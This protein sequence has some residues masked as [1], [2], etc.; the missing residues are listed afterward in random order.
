MEGEGFATMM[1]VTMDCMFQERENTIGLDKA[2]EMIM[3]KTSH[4]TWRLTNQD[5]YERH[6][7]VEAVKQ[8]HK[9]I[10]P[11]LHIE[12]LELQAENRGWEE[13]ERG[14]LEAYDFDY[15]L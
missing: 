5:A 10:M 8:L 15:S 11:S 7:Q 2:I 3:G 9:V 6:T 4:A 14:L 13:F 1:T 12:V